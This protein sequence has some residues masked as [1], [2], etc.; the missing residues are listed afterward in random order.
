MYRLFVAIDLPPEIKDQ[1]LAIGGGVPGARWLPPDQVHLTIRFIGEV[2]G[3]LF[4]DI[5]D[6]LGHVDAPPFRLTLKGVGHFPPRKNP[7]LLWI[8]VEGSESLV[9]LRNRI[10]AALSRAGVP[11]DSRKFTPHVTIAHLKNPSIPRVA[12]FL[13]GNGLLRYAPFEVTQFHLYSSARSSN[14]A[15]HQVEASY[16]LDAVPNLHR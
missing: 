15:D 11:R 16:T 14:G 9:L 2:D 6:S 1:C 3:G 13:A 4:R 12:A 8:G 7:E 5:V 10:E